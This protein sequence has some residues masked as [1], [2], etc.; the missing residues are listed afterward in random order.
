MLLFKSIIK[1]LLKNFTNYVVQN[2][3]TLKKQLLLFIALVLTSVGLFAQEFMVRGFVYAEESGEGVPFAKVIL[4]PER[5]D[6]PENV[7]GVTTNLDGFFTFPAVKEGKYSI[8]IRSAEHE[9]FQDKITVGEKEILNLNY[10]ISKGNVTEIEEIKVYAEDRSKKTKVDMS[11]NKL[12]QKGIERLPTF[13][14]E[15]D[16]MA[17]LA[18]TPGVVTTGDQGGQMYVRGGTP[19]QN[20]TLLDGMTV[21]NPFH[22]IGF[23]SV[24]ET[25]LIKNADIYT[26][27]FPARY[28][29]RI[30]SIMDIT[31]RDGNMK[32]FGG[33]VSA[34]PFMGKMVLEGPLFKSKDANSG[35]GGSYIFAAKQSIIDQ[36]SRSIYTHANDG[37]GLPFSFIDLHTKLTFKSGEGSRF[38]AFGF[39]NNDRVNYPELADLNWSAAGGGLNFRLVPSSSKVIVNGKFN[40]SNYGINFIESEGAAPRSSSITGFDLGFDFSY[41]LKNSSEVSYGVQIGG[42]NTDFITFNQANR[43]I[44]RQNFNTELNGYVDYRLVKGRWV[45]NPGLRLQSYVS[46]PQIVLE[47]RLGAKFNVTENFRLKFSGGK[48]SQNFTAAASDQDIVTLFY[49]FLSAP[50]DVQSNFTQPNGEVVRPENGIQI[51]WHSV[52]GFE[53]DLTR[54]LSLNIEGYY[55][56]FPQLSNINVNKVYDDIAEFSTIDDVYKKDF[57]IESGY[58]YGVD[59]LLKYSKNRIFLWGVYSYGKSERW[60]GFE[61]Y[62]PIFDRR[63]NIN[64]VGNYSFGKKKD[65][66]LSM[67]WNFGSGLPFTPT[68]GYFQPEPFDSG[69]TTDYTTSNANELSILLGTFNSARLPNYH[70][71]DIT[72]KK[73]FEFKNKSVLE[74]TIGVTNILNRENIFYVN[75]V[76]NEKIY[77]LPILPSIGV[78]FKF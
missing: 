58:A 73:R 31:Y 77:Q 44:Q 62:T 5:S 41:F 15:S 56:Y 2:F 36:T 17:A 43:I 69:V 4:T 54:Y 70:R 68:G 33:K 28:G 22:S 61:W 45:F 24:F 75:R 48:F 46:T 11:V 12:D 35:G 20:L 3:N 29:G 27:G 47:P 53:Y 30:A 19:I 8:V 57:I 18:V 67:R 38:S 65:L 6:N 16:V 34:S 50:T 78:S 52:A 9:E 40:V 71:F 76:T 55:K 26:G 72:A 51:A 21:Y 25:E 14:A 10:T 13:G 63:H 23:F 64:L 7:Q 42:F 60:D 74:T 1:L 59:F 37:R 39:Y 49:G 32:K 66:E